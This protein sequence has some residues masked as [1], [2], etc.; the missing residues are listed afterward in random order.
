M[1]E[2]TSLS[3]RELRE[4]LGRRE[5]SALDVARAH[6]ERIEALD[7]STVRSLL[8]V[9]RELAEA[10]ARLADQRL[11]A[12]ESAPLLG[13][14]MILKDVL[15]TRGVRTT[16]GSKILEHFIPIE[17]ATITRRLAEAG[18]LLLG[19]SN[20][21]EFAMGSSTENSAFFPTR[22]P[23]ALDRVPGV[24]IRAIPHRFRPPCLIT[25][26]RCNVN[27]ASQGYDSRYR[28]NTFPP[29]AWI[30]RSTSR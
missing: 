5:V 19:K 2:L 16:A 12:G 20:M 15:T 4:L 27:R 24:T 29:R 9:T 10:Q 22:N 25:P 6:L 18:T 30:Q 26:P 28:A 7:E 3:I 17:D 23:W 13:V 11:A 14:P 21:D 8:T 1:A